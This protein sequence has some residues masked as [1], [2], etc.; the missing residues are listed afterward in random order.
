MWQ[1]FLHEIARQLELAAVRQGGQKLFG[2][3]FDSELNKPEAYADRIKREFRLRDYAQAWDLYDSNRRYWENLY[4]DDPLNS[5]NHPASPPSSLLPRAPSAPTA[6][7]A[8]LNPASMGSGSPGPFGT[9]GQFRLGPSVSSQPLYETRSFVASPDDTARDAPDSRQL[10]RR[11][12]RVPG[13]GQSP[14][15]DGAPA[16][17]FVPANPIPPPGRPATFDERVRSQTPANS[18]SAGGLLGLIQDY[19]RDN[20][21]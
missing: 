4:G 16:V 6:G 21:Y 13:E 20:A 19:M 17:P 1:L 7:A 11:L 8:Y 12:V 15:D 18:A 2:K 14:F 10:V 9:G 3:L 5:R